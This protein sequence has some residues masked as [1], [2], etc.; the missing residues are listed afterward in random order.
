MTPD[1]GARL[2][3]SLPIAK[4]HLPA[5]TYLE[6]EGTGRPLKEGRRQGGVAPPLQRAT[7]ELEPH[8]APRRNVWGVAEVDDNGRAANK[9]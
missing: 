9:D 3:N 8:I 5:V 4:H 7:V 1:F 2:S 6:V